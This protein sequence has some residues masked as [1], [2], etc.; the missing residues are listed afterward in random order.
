MPETTMNKNHFPT[1][2]KDDIWRSWKV[3]GVQAKSI[4]R[5]M[6]KASNDHLRAGV[7]PS[8]PSHQSALLRIG[9]M[10][11]D[12]SCLGSCVACGTTVRLITQL[13]RYSLSGRSVRSLSHLLILDFSNVVYECSS[14]VL[15]KRN[16]YGVANK[17]SK[18]RK[19]GSFSGAKKRIVTRKTL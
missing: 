17:T 1:T 4:S 3:L 7:L 13:Y 12:H 19:V 6:K 5:A 14:Y 9:S 8:D 10:V 15:S 18:N 11:R 2:S 16:G